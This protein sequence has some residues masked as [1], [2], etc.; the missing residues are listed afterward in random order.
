MREEERDTDF[1]GRFET[2]TVYENGLPLRKL[3]ARKGKGRP[4]RNRA[5]TAAGKLERVELDEDGDGRVDHWNFYDPEGR[6]EKQERDTNGDGKA[7]TFVTLFPARGR[8]RAPSRTPTATARSRAAHK[9]RERRHTQ[10]ERPRTRRQAERVVRF[11]GGKPDSFEETRTSR[12]TRRCAASSA[13]RGMLSE[14]R[15][16]A[17]ARASIR[18]AVYE[19]GEKVAEER[20]TNGDGRPTW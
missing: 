9:R 3:A 12:Q 20:D 10:L 2:K 11:A 7:D 17:R 8:S 6:L 4:D 14:E 13:R 16:S 19:G 1:D 5:H 18:A 15:A